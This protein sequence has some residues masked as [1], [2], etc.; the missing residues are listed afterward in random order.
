MSFTKSKRQEHRH[1]NSF[2]DGAVLA[3]VA[4]NRELM[5]DPRYLVLMRNAG[6]QEMVKK[7][8]HAKDKIEERALQAQEGQAAE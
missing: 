6:W 8:Q 4:V 7:C 5:R 2:T 3:V 1:S